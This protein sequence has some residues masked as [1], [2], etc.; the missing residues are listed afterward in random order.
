MWTAL[1]LTLA[2][3]AQTASQQEPD[4]PAPPPIRVELTAQ[5]PEKGVGP[6]WSPKGAA[7]PLTSVGPML[8]GEFTLG[9][10]KTMPV[11]VA[12]GRTA[13][14]AQIDRLMIDCNRNGAFELEETFTTEPREQRGK[15]WASFQAT[16]DVPFPVEGGA[17]RHDP[18][19]MSLW[20]VFDPLEPDAAPALRWSR[21]GWHEGTFEL[22]GA[23]AFAFL[24][25][26]NQ[27][28]LFTRD[29][30][31]LLA[32][33][34][35]DLYA[36][37]ARSLGGHAW[38]DGRAYRVVTLAEDGSALTLEPFDPGVTEAEERERAD[39]MKADR[40]APR[41]ATPLAFGHDLAAALAEAKAKGKRVFVD[42]ETTWCGPCK[43]MDEVVYTA[44]DVVAAASGVVAVKLDGDVER[45][46]V[47]RYGVKA[48]PTL[49]LLDA[50]GAVLRR[51]VGY[52]SVVNTAKF[53]RE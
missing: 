33:E 8:I 15:W 43:Q 27:D 49:L 32:R 46:L 1:A 47:K 24:S 5:L 38:L 14:A 40:E 3:A 16:V 21:R 13:G 39:L 45:E 7:V 42:F 48:Y 29:D 50:E 12:L 22:G 35:K 52:T 26:L 31:W 44:A 34:R 20:Y 11:Q 51:T 2:L 53:L 19:P 28:G 17:P 30:V 41:A 23:P 36:P 18:Y 25:E 6:R 4:A 9:P 10:A 37:G